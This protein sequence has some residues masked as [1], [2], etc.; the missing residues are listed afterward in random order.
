MINPCKSG[1]SRMVPNPNASTAIMPIP[2]PLPSSRCRK[3]KIDPP[4]S[5]SIEKTTISVQTSESRPKMLKMRSS[6]LNFS[7]WRSYFQSSP[8][9]KRKARL[10]SMGISSQSIKI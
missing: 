3:D 10:R 1:H 7:P 6:R 4:K 8:C 2:S 5:L 9:T